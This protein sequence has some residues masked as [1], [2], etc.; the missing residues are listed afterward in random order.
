M[1]KKAS[2]SLSLSRATT[3][4]VLYL[5]F[6]VKVEEEMI[7]AQGG[8]LAPPRTDARAPKEQWSNSAMNERR[9]KLITVLRRIF[10]TFG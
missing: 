7:D 5:H 1:N 2:L 10:N 3:R 4:N 6:G 9:T 8:L